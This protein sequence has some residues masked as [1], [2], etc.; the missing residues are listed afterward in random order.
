M[1][2]AQDILKA[3]VSN[4]APPRAPISHLSLLEQIKMVR[5]RFI[6]FLFFSILDIVQAKLMKCCLVCMGVDQNRSS[7]TSVQSSQCHPGERQPPR[8]LRHS[9]TRSLGFSSD[10]A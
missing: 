3:T 4:S 2:C 8:A 6:I 5:P 9:Q 1:S 10:A 7:A